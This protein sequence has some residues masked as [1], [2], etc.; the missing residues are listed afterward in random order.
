M[1]TKFLK[2]SLFTVGLTI[3]IGY[4]FFITPENNADEISLSVL[5]AQAQSNGEGSGNE[6]FI[7]LDG[8]VI[9]ASGGLSPQEM[10]FLVAMQLSA[11]GYTDIN[12]NLGNG[13]SVSGTSTSST[14][15]GSTSSSTKTYHGFS[16][17]VGNVMK[18]KNF[19]GGITGVSFASA[20]VNW[21]NDSY[22]IAYPSL[23]C[24]DGWSLCPPQYWF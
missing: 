22:S 4:G 6:I 15:S 12:L 14:S 1:L 11:N 21:M 16:W 9:R 5:N 17:Q 20:S 23:G 24:V 3:A 19:S 10:A 13:M 18:T 8:V 2:Y 7:E